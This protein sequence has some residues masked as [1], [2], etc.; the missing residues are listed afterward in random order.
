MKPAPLNDSIFYN[1]SKSLINSPSWRQWLTQLPDSITTII[2]TL[3]ITGTGF[4]HVANGIIESVAK[5]ITNSDVASNASITESKLNLNYPTHSNVNDPTSGQKAALVGTSGTPSANNTYVTDDDSRN[6]NARTPV[7]HQLDSASFHTVSGLTTGD[8]LKATAANSFGFVAHGLTYSDV[9]AD[10][11][12]S[13]NTV[14]S[15]LNTH[16]NL[17]TAAHGGIIP[18]TRTVMGY[19]LS[20]NITAGADPGYFTPANPTFL[21]ST[22]YTMFGLG[23]NLAI[24]PLISGKVRFAISFYSSGVG[25]NALNNFKACYGTGTAPLNGANATGTVVGLPRPGGSVASTTSTQPTVSW[26]FIVKGLTINTA[27]WFDIQGARNANNTSVGLTS[28]EA[29]LEELPY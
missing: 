24:T 13:A 25:A 12:G 16:A 8:F 5:L 23:G 11:N 3:T 4:I 14:Q 7:A 20:S 29:T 27:Y 22:G 26:N 28:A 19:S 9:G 21:T 15:N 18:S 17:T 6:T 2:N 1:N 10:A